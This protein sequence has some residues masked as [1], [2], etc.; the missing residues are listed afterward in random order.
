M[1]MAT[2]T[3]TKR[4]STSKEH[5]GGIRGVTNIPFYILDIGYERIFYISTYYIIYLSVFAFSHMCV[6]CQNKKKK[7]YVVGII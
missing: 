6:I 3:E 1:A 5:S 4:I 2:F 7:T